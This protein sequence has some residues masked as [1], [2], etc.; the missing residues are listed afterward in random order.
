[1]VKKAITQY[2]W[3]A[4]AKIQVLEAPGLALSVQSIEKRGG[5]KKE[6][7]YEFNFSG[8]LNKDGKI[9]FDSGK[10]LRGWFKQQ[11]RTIRPTLGEA[12]QYGLRCLSTPHPGSIEI[13][14]P[15]GLK[16]TNK[17]DVSD[18]LQN[19]YRMPENSDSFPYPIKEAFT[20]GH[21]K[22]MRSVFSFF[23]V[24]PM[25]IELEVKLI[26]FARNFTPEMAEWMLKKLGCVSGIGDKYSNGHGLF[27]LVSFDATSEKIPL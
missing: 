22:D 4:N 8:W 21:G 11:S 14:E 26:S 10:R 27:E 17:E 25:N 13:A 3:E 9:V 19:A 5:I 12:L 15:T 7:Y 6:R 18:T 16:G 2:F 1:M 20:T 23:Y 24:L